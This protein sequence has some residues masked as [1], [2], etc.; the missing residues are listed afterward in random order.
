MNKILILQSLFSLFFTIFYFFISCCLFYLAIPMIF[1]YIS[2]LFLFFLCWKSSFFYFWQCHSNQHLLWL[3]YSVQCFDIPD[4][5]HWKTNT[6]LLSSFV[7]NDESSVEEINTK[8]AHI[9]YVNSKEKSRL[10]F[11]RTKKKEKTVKRQ[12]SYLKKRI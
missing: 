10:F 2:H 11:F 3:I 6:H 9:W 7:Q 4:M 8:C 5:W 1:W 12:I